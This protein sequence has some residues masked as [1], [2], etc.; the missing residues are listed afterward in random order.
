MVFIVG[1]FAFH[2]LFRPRLAIVW[3]VKQV[4]KIGLF[5]QHGRPAEVDNTLQTKCLR[6][7]ISIQ[8]ST[9]QVKENGGDVPHDTPSSDDLSEL[10]SYSESVRTETPESE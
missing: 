9:A 3:E 7:F 2:E 5:A 6:T 1:D 4:N 8:T 10:G